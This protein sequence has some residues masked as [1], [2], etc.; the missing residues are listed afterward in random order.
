MHVRKNKLGCLKV[1]SSGSGE[2]A[3]RLD[4]RQDDGKLLEK[5][6]RELHIVRLARAGATLL[7]WDVMEDEDCL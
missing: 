4:F 6:S 5:R 1:A 2:K 7:V 3:H